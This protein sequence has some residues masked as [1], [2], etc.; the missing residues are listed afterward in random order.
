MSR[1]VHY[2]QLR[3]ATYHGLNRHLLASRFHEYDVILTTYE[4]L[5]LDC[6][7]QG[8]LY[9][10]QWCRLVLDEGMKLPPCNLR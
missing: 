7:A 2:S 8:P 4:T 10:N 3:T 9:Q 6:E 1:H 5:R